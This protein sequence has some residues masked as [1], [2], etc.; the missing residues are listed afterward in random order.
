MFNRSGFGLILV[1]L[2]FSLIGGSL[3][4]VAKSDVDDEAVDVGL[5]YSVIDPFLDYPVLPDSKLPMARPDTS[6]VVTVGRGEY[7]PASFV[8]VAKNLKPIEYSIRVVGFSG[9]DNELSN[10]DVDIRYVSSWYQSSGAWDSQKI[11]R[12]EPVLVPELLVND[13]DLIRND[14]IAKKSYLKTFVKKDLLYMDIS[15][16]SSKN[17]RMWKKTIIKDASDLQPIALESGI[18]QMWITVHVPENYHS[19]EYAGVIE[20]K[21]GAETLYIPL[22]VNV[23][24]FKLSKPTLTYSLYYRG[25]FDPDNNE[26]SSEYKNEQQLETELK[27]IVEHGF[28]CP[29]LYQRFVA[30][31]IRDSKGGTKPLIRKHMEFREQA[32]VD[33]SQLYYLGLLAPNNPSTLN[34]INF[35]KQVKKFGELVK[36]FGVNDFYIYAVDEAKGEGLLKQLESWGSAKRSGAKIFAAGYARHVDTMRGRTNLLV[37]HGK[38]NIEVA[39]KVHGYGNAIFS[40]SNPQSGPENP[41]LYR[42]NYGYSLLANEFDGAMIYAYQHGFGNVWNDYDHDIYRDHVLA[43]PTT[44]GVID[45][46]AW[47]GLREAVDD[48]R[49]F[50]AYLGSLPD[51]ERKEMNERFRQK[52][53]LWFGK[54]NPVS[55]AEI[56]WELINEILEVTDAQGGISERGS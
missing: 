35:E 20:V 5:R 6:V 18:Q 7:E 53:R 47:E 8:L 25:R 13:P 23:L 49:Y 31:Y 1:G 3:N 56:R 2:L 45:T 27:N 30:K 29:T 21:G 37:F 10:Q 12:G 44:D 43:Y 50:E 48:V 34:L 19:G 39:N 41:N 26:V 36:P 46:I 51:D 16:L 24:P 17:I 28:C 40:Y 22:E 55:P 38:P 15:Q 32:G 54:T 42:A 11:K 52:L 4:V 33:N 14:H 9:R